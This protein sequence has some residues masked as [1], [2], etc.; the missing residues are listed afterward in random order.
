MENFFQWGLELISSIQQ[1]DLPQVDLFF[2][3]ITFLG[4]ETFYLILFPFLL[5]CIDFNF[6]LRLGIIFLLS[7]Y[8]NA[9]AKTF[10]HLPRPFEILPEIQKIQA[11][12]YGF[13]SGH[14]QSSMVVWGNIA[15]WK[16]KRPLIRNLCILLI[17]LIAFSRIYLGVHFPVDILGGWLIGAFLIILGYFLLF[18]N[19]K[20]LLPKN[21]T[22]QLIG[23][24]FFP[25]ILLSFQT[26]NDMVSSIAALMGVGY[27]LIL[28]QHTMGGF[29]PET[30]IKRLLSFLLGIIGIAI[31]YIGL[32][33][34]LPEEGH[35]F[36]QTGRF[37]RYLLLGTW[38]SFGAPRLFIQTGLVR[39]IKPNHQ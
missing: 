13:P 12:G 34:L 1:V 10:F 3:M 7:V 19:M 38:I 27:G 2:Q 32:K 37:F 4:D 5:W 28:L 11:T 18:R 16:K 8:I 35:A 39:Q 21:M 6:G 14:A 31:L 30:W 17:F 26:S 29:Q 9:G 20:N 22:L 25:L 36:Y 24:T 15:L 33:I 23:L